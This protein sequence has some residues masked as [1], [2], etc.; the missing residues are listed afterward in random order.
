MNGPQG[1]NA[2]FQ[3]GEGLIW[4][5]PSGSGLCQLRNQRDWEHRRGPAQ[6][7]RHVDFRAVY[8]Y[9]YTYIHIYRHKYIRIH[10]VY[11]DNSC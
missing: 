11:I 1:S 2:D 3:I 4:V 10:T 9:V 8:V 7:P 5:H 6:V